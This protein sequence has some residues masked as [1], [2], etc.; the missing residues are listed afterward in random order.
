MSIHS[1][2]VLVNGMLQFSSIPA[3]TGLASTTA[4]TKDT[5]YLKFTETNTPLTIAVY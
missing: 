5:I 4:W 3:Y 1:H 2:T